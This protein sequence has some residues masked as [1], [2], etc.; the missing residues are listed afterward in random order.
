MKENKKIYLI[1]VIL[2][3]IF[4]SS[5]VEKRMQND[6]FFYIPIGKYIAETHGIDGLDHWSIHENLRF[7]YSRMDL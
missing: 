1:Y 6:T 5:I 2:I 7:T 4:T 3:I